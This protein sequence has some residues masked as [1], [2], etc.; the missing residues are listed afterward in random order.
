MGQ[1]R[2]ALAV[3]RKAQPLAESLDDPARRAAV[4]GALGKTLW[5]TGATDEAHRELERSIALARQANAPQIA[6]A[7][8]NHLGNLYADQ[9]NARRCP[10]GL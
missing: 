4:L 1:Q 6:A 10:H 2:N 3:L 5:L 7:S 8:L 9:G